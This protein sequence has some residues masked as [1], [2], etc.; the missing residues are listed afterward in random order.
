MRGSKGPRLYE[1]E[2]WKA[3]SPPDLKSYLIN[4]NLQMDWLLDGIQAIERNCDP[5]IWADGL[6]EIE[7]ITLL[8]EDRRYFRHAGFDWWCLPRILRQIATL[9]RVGG[10]ST[11]EQQLVRTLLERRERTMRRK[12]R[13]VLLAWI[14]THR[15]SKRDVLRTY[16][17][18][19]YFGYK[20]RGCDEASNLIFG[21]DAG[22]LDIQ[23]ASFVASML[24]YPLP[25]TVRAYAWHSGLFP[26]RDGAGLLDATSV[27]APR[28][29]KNMKRR[30]A[31]GAALRGKAK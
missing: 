19:A 10:V 24:V 8:L 11:I 23:G 25:K 4:L 1:G 16:L 7:R 26:A 12:A 6:T 5:I 31:Y 30:S 18:T 14:L 17:S 20:L 21:T 3:R 27:I 13:E 28:W 22:N 9:K 2:G 15:K 29:S